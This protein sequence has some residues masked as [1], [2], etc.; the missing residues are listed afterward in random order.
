MIGNMIYFL[1]FEASSLDAG[2]YPIEIGWVDEDGQG[3]SYLIQ[4]H[5][6]WRGWS[7]RSEAIY[8]ITQDMLRDGTD[9]TV[10]ARRVQTILSD[11]NI[12]SDEPA[13]DAYWLEMLL[14]V[15]DAPPL[16]VSDIDALIGLEMRRV[17]SAI[18]AE[19]NT[20]EWYRQSRLRMDEAQIQAVM[21]YE[22]ASGRKPHR[23]LPDAQALWRG[24]KAVCRAIDCLV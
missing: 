16:R 14:K 4:P 7:K 9:A 15:I 5:W 6:S 2:S 18:T 13:F 17:L 3:E 10:V 8:H 20:S 11:A 12:I 24:W 23:A 22:D 21:A 1:D 19:P